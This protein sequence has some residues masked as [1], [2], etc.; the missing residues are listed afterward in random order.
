MKAMILAAGFGKRLRPLT[1]YTP[2]P[3][4]VVRG[5]PLI[6][7]HIVRLADTGIR[8][9]V[10]N[11]AWL[12]EKLE[13]YL[14]DGSELGV[15][16][17]WSREAEPLETGGGICKA[18]PLLGDA[19]FLLVNGDVWT[20]YP[21]RRLSSRQLERNCRAH[22]VLVSNPEHNLQGDYG[23]CRPD[24]GE[25]NRVDE[26]AEIFTGRLVMRQDSVQNYTFSGLSLIDPCLFDGFTQGSAFPL[27][28]ALLPAL[29][30]GQLVG[31]LYSGQWCDVGT[32]ER[33]NALN[34]VL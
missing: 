16:I 13:G 9:I 24:S 27:R 17:H 8:D 26:D 28:D 5:K 29:R 11:T 3:L 2:K 34:G 15:N 4:L 12:G 21:L 10:I 20:D 32:L 33:L 25:D 6:V 1:E 18:L 31:E 7:H 30:N 19:P 22:L 23:F 14:G